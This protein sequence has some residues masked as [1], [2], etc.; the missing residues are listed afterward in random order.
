MKRFAKE[1]KNIQDRLDALTTLLERFVELDAKLVRT[2]SESAEYV[3][4]R[5]KKVALIDEIKALNKRLVDLVSGTI[6]P[7]GEE[8]LTM[9]PTDVYGIG[10]MHEEKAEAAKVK[11]NKNAAFDV[12]GIGRLHDDADKVAAAKELPEKVKKLVTELN[13][14]YAIVVNAGSQPQEVTNARRTLAINIKK[15]VVNLSLDKNIGVE[16][17]GLTEGL[18]KE[19]KEEQ[20]KAESRA[21]ARATG[22]AELSSG[23]HRK[24]A[25]SSEESAAEAEMRV[26]QEEEGML[27]EAFEFG[28]R[29][30]EGGGYEAIG[31]RP[32]AAAEIKRSGSY[33]PA[34]A[35]AEIKRSGSYQQD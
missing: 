35:A 4:L 27:G 26:R 24:G 18:V 29:P 23:K 32:A 8:R 2:T 10:R 31:E 34:A 25:A 1:E 28:D 7:T 6:A 17:I 22:M 11:L 19:V 15:L 5:N 14:L 13:A 21:A 30:G 16:E 3:T 20:A 9:A 33:Q 12:Y